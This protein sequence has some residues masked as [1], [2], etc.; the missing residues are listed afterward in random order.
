MWHSSN[1]KL[2]SMAKDFFPLFYMHHAFTSA[3][4]SFHKIT[5]ECKTQKF[6]FYKSAWTRKKYVLTLGSEYKLHSRQNK[7]FPS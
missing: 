5:V 7:K 6:V 2:T 4:D 3:S 1:F